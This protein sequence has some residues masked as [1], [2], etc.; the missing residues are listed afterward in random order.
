MFKVNVIYHI[1]K[2]KK[3]NHKIIPTDEVKASDKIQASLL[4]K[5]LRKLGIEGISPT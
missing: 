1:N 3:K 4:I 2:L 5:V